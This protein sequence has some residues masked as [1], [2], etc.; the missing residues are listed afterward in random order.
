MVHATSATAIDG[1]RT[2]QWKDH[3]GNQLYRVNLWRA[4]SRAKGYDPTFP[5]WW[6]KRP[7][8][9]QGVPQD[10]PPFV[11]TIEIM[12]AIFADYEMNYRKFE[13]WHNQ[14]R[15]EMLNLTLHE[16]HSKVFSLLKPI[17]KA[18]L[19]HLEET[20]DINILGISDDL[21]QIHLEHPPSISDTSVVQVEGQQLQV[22]DVDGSL[23]TLASPLH[24]E[25]SEVVHVTQHYSTIDQ[26]QEHLA[27]FWRPRWWRDTPAPSDWDRMFRFCE[28]YLSQQPEHHDPITVAQWR[29]VNKRYNQRSARGPDGF[30]HKDL[31]YMPF[32][33]EDRLVDQLNFW[34][35]VGQFP[36]Q[37]HTGFI[38]PLPKREQSSQVGDFR[39][40]II[41]SMVY[42]S[43]ASLRSRQ[44][45]KRMANM[46][47]A[48]QFGFIPNRECIEVWMAIQAVI[49]ESILLGKDVTGFVSD[50]VKAFEFLP[51]QPIL[52]LGR[53]L[54]ISKRDL[55]SGHIF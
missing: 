37:L 16:N 54:G 36:S 38:H 6:Q 22:D 28:V 12:R 15:A 44:I 17:G 39:P 32:A 1:P 11:P 27:Q 40:V 2:E 34:E 33:F 41:Y 48:H 13:S 18:P 9:L 52:W 50:I 26:L 49:E 7:I 23:L 31:H 42:R 10:W 3:M 25:H 46:I 20:T 5:L 53:R 30:S 8:Q 4:I 43:W 55:D 14:Q 24:D 45:L 47:G 29:E 51:R 35:E 21:M 19:Q